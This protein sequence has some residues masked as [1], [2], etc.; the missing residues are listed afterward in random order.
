MVPRARAAAPYFSAECSEL[1]TVVV[2]PGGAEH[3]KAI[4][5]QELFAETIIPRFR[6]ADQD[7]PGVE[8]E[9]ARA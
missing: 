7:T 5:A 2:N 9:P 4:K 1:K 6:G 8:A 3:W